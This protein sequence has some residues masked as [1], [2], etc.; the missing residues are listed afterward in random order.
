VRLKALIRTTINQG[1]LSLTDS[2]PFPH[3]VSQFAQDVS[4]QISPYASLNDATP[5]HIGEGKWNRD[6]RFTDDQITNMYEG[7]PIF[8]DRHFSES[9]A[10]ATYSRYMVD[11]DA[12]G[13]TKHLQSMQN[14]FKQWDD[15]LDT[16][17]G[18]YWVEP[19]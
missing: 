4:W 17:K 8:N 2:Y 16:S 1:W 7:D 12:A 14:V 3:S 10:D 9:I 15:R 11:G 5:F 6:R 19:L 13:V 18:L